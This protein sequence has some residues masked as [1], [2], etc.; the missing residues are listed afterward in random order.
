AGLMP[1]LG[2]QVPCRAGADAPLT[3]HPGDDCGSVFVVMAPPRL[4]FLAA[5][6]RA[7]SQRF[8]PALFRLSLLTSRVIQGIRF[9]GALQLTLHLIGEG[10]IAQPPAPAVA[11]ADMDS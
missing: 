6:T 8:L 3:A 9:H 4:A 1:C 5:P 10:R 2:R 11:C 7:A